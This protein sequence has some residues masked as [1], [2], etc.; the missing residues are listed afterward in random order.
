MRP[1][2]V[3]SLSV[4]QVV[5]VSAYVVGAAA[6][7]AEAVGAPRFTSLAIGGTETVAVAIAAGVLL[8]P[9][10]LATWGHKIKPQR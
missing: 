1:P 2:A 5:D 6:L 8:V 10:L 3:G 9:A 4:Q 7:L